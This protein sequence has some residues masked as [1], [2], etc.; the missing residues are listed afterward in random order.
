MGD[1]VK[2]FVCDLLAGSFIDLMRFI[3]QVRPK[4]VSAGD[5]FHKAPSRAKSK[6]R[7]NRKRS[8]IVH[9]KVSGQQEGRPG[10]KEGE[11]LGQGEGAREPVRGT[12]FSPRND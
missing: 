3:G 6:R 1:S 10:Q 9:L 8:A 7:E 4:E 11:K 12:I 5:G 2:W